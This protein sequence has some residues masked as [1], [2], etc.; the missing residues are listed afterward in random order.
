MLIGKAGVAKSALC[1]AEADRIE[2]RGRDL[3]A[4]LM[5][6][7]SFTEFFF[8]LMT[9]HEASAKQ[10][11]FLDVL[12]IAIA[13]HGLTPTAIASR[14]TYDADPQ[15]LQAALAAGI[16]GCGTVI[17]GTS[18][19]CGKLLVDAQKRVDAGAAP[20]EV[21][22]ALAREVHGRGDKLPGF[23]H[24]IHRPLDP[25]TE[26]IFALADT[27][28][29][30]G[31]HVDLARR[32]APAAAKV[33]GRQLPMNVSMTIAACLLDL[34]FPAT[35]IKAIPL[36]ARTAGLLAHLAEEQERPIG[37]LM[38]SA[39]EAAIDYDGGKDT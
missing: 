39:A 31:R 15:S 34:D 17:L 19:L 7:Q 25:R 26:R 16:L 4:D 18:E 21:A 27:E 33:W 32:L 29:V 6:K 20:D 5:G 30:S 10:R 11:F 2:I 22:E 37:F 1:H 28:G 35:M 13:E 38:A 3:V 36:L 23:G 8:F 24:P 14:M 12:L 9:G